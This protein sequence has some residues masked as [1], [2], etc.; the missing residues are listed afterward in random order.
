MDTSVTRNGLPPQRVM[1]ALASASAEAGL[2]AVGARL[3]RMHSNTV[4]YLPASNAVA[5]INSGMA[6]DGARRVAASLTATQWLAQQGFPTVRPKVNRVV[7]RDGL[8]VSFWEHEQTVATGRSLTALARLLR[9]L[10]SF[11]DVALD[12]PPMPSPLS[13]VAQALHHHP[14]AFDGNDRDWLSNEISDCQRRW[15]GMKFTLPAGLVHGDAHPNNLLYTKRGIL[16]GDWDHVGYGPR[17]WDLVQAVYFHRRFPAAGDDL[18]GAAR[19]YGWDLRVWSGADDLI[20]IREVSGLGSYIRTAAA[21]PDAR[22][23]LAYRIMTLRERDITAPWNS[24][25]RS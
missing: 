11:R 25:S 17:E 20:G 24:P 7:V 5:R 14:E 10:H 9:K 12:L 3:M 6:I 18:D 23:E 22:A 15:A 16:L 21:K 2:I 8:V 19:V 4:F 1:D 13:G